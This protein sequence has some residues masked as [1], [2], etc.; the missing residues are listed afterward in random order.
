MIA[1]LCSVTL[2]AL[3]VDEVLAV[4]ERAGLDAIEW[5]ADVHV[6]PGDPDA[7]AVARRSADAG[8]RVASYGSYLFAGRLT[9]DLV[10]RTLDTAVGMGAPNVRVWTDWV[11]PDPAPAERTRIVEDL[12]RA[13]SMAAE[14]DLTLSLEFHEGTLT[15][16][17]GSTLRLL[18]DVDAPNLF[19]YWQPP[20]GMEPDGALASWRQVRARASHLHVF[21]WRGHD[22]RQPLEEGSDLWP[23]VLADAPT[24]GPWPH[25]RVALLEFVRDDS[26]DQLVAD[27]AVLKRWICV[28]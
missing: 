16:T 15:E 25:E 6:P 23:A 2:R 8:L 18:D 5:G 10:E 9:D 26:P 4:G 24:D 11:G 12:Q 1:G 13:A 20:T 19:T 14:R 22:D 17:A 21:R 7:A 3:P 28:P 27:A